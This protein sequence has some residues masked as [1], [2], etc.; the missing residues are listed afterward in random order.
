MT[1]TSIDSPLS[2]SITL[3]LRASNFPVPRILPTVAFFLLQDYFTDSP[4][5][6]RNLSEHIRFPKHIRLYFLVYFLFHILFFLAFVWYRP[7]KLT[8][9]SFWAHFK[10]ARRIV[11]SSGQFICC[12]RGF[13]V[14]VV[15]TNRGTWQ[16]VSSVVQLDTDT[17]PL[18]VVTG[19]SSNWRHWRRCTDCKWHKRSHST[20]SPVSTGV[21][22]VSGRANHLGV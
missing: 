5:C 20:S 2:P 14:L 3:P 21:V 7:I 9:V 15:Y 4:G 10:I 22:T 18:L 19:G 6:F 8:Y 1:G 13:T 12:E 16:N 17:R 11:S